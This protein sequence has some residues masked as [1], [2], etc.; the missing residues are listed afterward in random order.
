MTTRQ[1]VNRRAWKMYAIMVCPAIALVL[2]GVFVSPYPK[3]Y[4]VLSAV[5]MT[6]FRGG[7]PVCFVQMRRTRCLRC[8]IALGYTAVL[9][10]RPSI[11]YQVS[12]CPHCAS[13]IDEQER[14]PIDR[15]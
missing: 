7:L 1:Y 15:S 4:A 8:G 5:A 12:R 10:A 2:F 9:I 11:G 14:D 3:L 13:S 6:L